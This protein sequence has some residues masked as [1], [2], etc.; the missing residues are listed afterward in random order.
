MGTGRLNMKRSTCS[1][2]AEQRRGSSN[3][4]TRV[5]LC[6]T[7]FLVLGAV[8]ASAQSSAVPPT[9][10]VQI[11]GVSPTTPT[12]SNPPTAPVG[13]IILYG[14]KISPITLQPVRHLWIGDSNFGMCRVDP[15]IDAAN[16]AMAAAPAGSPSPFNVNIETCPFKLN[17]LSVT[18]GPMA[19]DP[20]TNK[21]YLT[22][23]QTNAEAILRIGYLPTGDSGDGALDFNSIF[24]MTGNITGSRLSGGTTG[25]PFPNDSTSGGTASPLGRPNAATLGPDGN[26]YV[27]F[28]KTGGIIRINNPATADTTGFGTC[29][30]FVQLVAATPTRGGGNGMAFVGSDLWGADAGGPFVIRN[31]AT[32]CQALSQ[33]APQTPTC[34]AVR[35][36]NGAFAALA[37][38]QV[39]SDQT[40]PYLNGNNLYFGNAT[41]DMWVGNISGGGTIVENPFEPAGIFVLNGNPVV[42]VNGV[43]ADMTDPANVVMYSGDDPSG[44]ALLGQGR[45]WQVFQNPPAKADKAP[46][47]T[48]VRASAVGN[49]ITIS[50]S[51][52]QSGQQITSYT[53]H[54]S[55]V[56]VG[57]VVPDQTVVPAAGGSF[58]PNF[59]VLSGLA[60]GVYAFR[61]TAN[62]AF[63]NN[64]P[65]NPSNNVSLPNVVPP[66]IP[67]NVTATAGDTVAFVNFVAP[68][69][70]ATQGI[71]GYQITSQPA[72]GVSPV[73]AATAT[74]GTVTGLTDGTTYTFTVH[75]INAGGNGM[76]STPSNPVTPAAK[77]SV[78]ISLTGPVSEPTV[79]VQATFTSTL[80]NNTATDVTATTFTFVLSQ[81]SPDG[82]NILTAT[83]GLG[84]CTA[85]GPGVTTISCS[86][87]TLAAGAA[88]NVS[89]IVQIV[90]NSVTGAA[91]YTATDINLNTVSGTSSFT[92]ATPTAPPVGGAGPTVAI[93]VTASSAKPQMNRA[94]ATTHTFGVSNTTST[95]V[96]GVSF[97]ISEPAQ[98][99]IGTIT[100]I[101][102]QP[103][104]GTPTCGAPSPGVLNGISV[105]NIV[106]TIANLG[107]NLKGGGKLTAPQSITVTVGITA[108][109]VAMSATVQGALVFNGIDSLNPVASFTQIVK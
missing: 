68:P 34:P 24:S 43:T 108:P 32:T 9:T 88:V 49:T 101:S 58:P 75:A 56:P 78:T 12:P 13:G 103:A 96:S 61:V 44:A 21:I 11:L 20:N 99:V 19:F 3:F 22:D 2:V 60:N 64:G 1:A 57:V 81:A 73:L 71:T 7:V 91:S 15:D 16:A 66:L 105:N 67:T 52:A 5:C 59:L 77:P 39:Y 36:N 92:I 85:G 47:P 4:A 87:G 25:C 94:T 51:P 41:D 54:A 79:P 69:N 100:A 31:V 63:G 74:S 29:D 95:V 40:Y 33:I 35:A 48:V 8:S 45:W 37:P 26:L 89:I 17:G 107:G 106:C 27:G 102:S 104:L 70:A 14:S 82:A 55:T 98:F 10:A 62:N 46:Q 84:T 23:E 83:T 93:P 50:W 86:I 90:S 6:L 109:N 72:G 76:E 28:K 97:T 18:G 65:S 38:T 80:T 53:V 42:N 30:D